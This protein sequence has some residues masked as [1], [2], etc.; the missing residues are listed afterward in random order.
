MTPKQYFLRLGNGMTS[1]P[2]DERTLRE[3]AAMGRL[4]ENVGIA[5]S[6]DGPWHTLFHI[7]CG[8]VIKVQRIRDAEFAIVDQ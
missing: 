1:G 4:T 6:Q 5:L 3:L 8:V 7:P 2:V